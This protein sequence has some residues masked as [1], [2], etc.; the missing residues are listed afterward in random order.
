MAES[1]NRVRQLKGALLLIGILVFGSVVA[2]FVMHQKKTKSGQSGDAAIINQKAMITLEGIHH[3]AIKE[4]VR[5]WSLDAE[6]ADYHLEDNKV[7]FNTMRVVFYS[8]GGDA[9]F[10]SAPSGT[11]HTVSNDLDVSGHVMVKNRQYELQTEK[12][13]YNHEKRMCVTDAPVIITS[14]AI[15][16]TADNMRYD[17]GRDV[18]DLDNV[19]GIIDEDI[20]L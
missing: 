3:T 18:I 12:L 7:F 10:L 19:A 14:E 1:S 15:K 4:G 13:T 16:I 17:L 6:S 20:E 11:W 5:E 9:I 8:E 2:F